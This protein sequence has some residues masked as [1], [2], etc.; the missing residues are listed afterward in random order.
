M[1]LYGRG[2][3]EIEVPATWPATSSAWNYEILFQS[4]N[5]TLFRSMQSPSTKGRNWKQKFL[6]ARSKSLFSLCS[7]QPKPSICT[8]LMIHI[9]YTSPTNRFR[10][11]IIII[12]VLPFYFFDAECRG[13]NYVSALGAPPHGL[14]S[15]TLVWALSQSVWLPQQCVVRKGPGATP[16]RC[17]R[18]TD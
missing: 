14:F 11:Q 2:E 16:W 9:F 3:V 8:R 18:S 17:S 7:V 15:T 5:K 6:Q 10:K 12:I 13:E 4:R 1:A